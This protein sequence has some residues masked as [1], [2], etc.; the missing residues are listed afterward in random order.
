MWHPF[1]KLQYKET[2]VPTVP[3]KMREHETGKYPLNTEKSGKDS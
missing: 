3:V 2:Y 1:V